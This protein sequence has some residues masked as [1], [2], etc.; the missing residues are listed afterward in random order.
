MI[1]FCLPHEIGMNAENTCFFNETLW[2]VFL[3]ILCGES[4]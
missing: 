2:N 4:R 1:F 3:V